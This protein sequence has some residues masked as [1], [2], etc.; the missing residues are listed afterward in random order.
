MYDIKDIRLFWTNDSGFLSQFVDKSPSDRFKVRPISVHP[1]LINDLSFWLPDTVMASQ[2]TSDTYDIIRS[3][4]GS[5]VEQVLFNYFN[6]F[7]ILVLSY[8]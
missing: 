7:E 5:L 6:I 3:L 4:G 8:N 1:Q 2:I